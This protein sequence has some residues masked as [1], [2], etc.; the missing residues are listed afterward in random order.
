[1]DVFLCYTPNTEMKGTLLCYSWT[2][3]ILLP[4]ALV[5]LLL[6]HPLLD[7]IPQQPGESWP[8]WLIWRNIARSFSHQRVS[9]LWD[10]SVEWT[11]PDE[12]TGNKRDSFTAG[13]L[14]DELRCNV[15]CVLRGSGQASLGWCCRNPIP[16]ARPD[17]LTGISCSIPVPRW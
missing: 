2:S 15:K 10:P 1:M 17:L 7:L 11:C 9:F 13:S 4:K 8:N 3:L 5:Q 12:H 6:A 14:L 16:A